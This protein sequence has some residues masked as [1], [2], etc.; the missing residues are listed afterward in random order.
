MRCSRDVVFIF[1]RQSLSL[2]FSFSPSVV[3]YARGNI[4]TY[5]GIQKDTEN[6]SSRQ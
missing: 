4:N 5:E 2:A 3:A 1:T 6:G